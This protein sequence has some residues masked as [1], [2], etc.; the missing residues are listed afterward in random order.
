VSEDTLSVLDGSTFVV[1]DRHGDVRSGDGRVHGFFAEDTRFI[2]RWAL[3]V[4]DRPLQLLSLDQGTHFDAQFFLTPAVDP[5]EQAPWSIMRHRL[6]DHVWIEEIVFTNHLHV[7]S[8]IRLNLEVAADF[9]DLF[10]VKDV[11]FADR[12]VSFTQDS[13]G[14]TLAYRDGDFRRSV[15]VATSSTATI[16]REG[17]TYELELAPGQQ[18]ATTLTISPHAAQPGAQFTQRETRGTLASVRAARAAELE[19]W[20]QTAPSLE[21]EDPELLRTYRASLSD[22]AA[23][24]MHPD[25]HLGATLPAAGLPWFMAL[26]GR[27]SLI[28]SF[29]TLPYLP[30]LAATTLRVLSYRQAVDRDDFHERE[31]GKILHELRFGELTARG[32]RPHS[33]YFGT[34][35]ATPLFLVLLGEYHRWS[36]DDALVRELEGNA[37][38]ALRWIEESG[39]ADGDGFVEYERRNLQTG[40]VNQCWKDSWDSMQFADGTLARG[41]IATCEIQG[42]VYDA[43]RRSAVLARDVWGDEPFADR[44]EQ[45]ARDLRAR[46]QQK[47]WMPE[48]GC[49]ALAL[50]G[51]K[52]QVDSLTSNIGHLLWS[53]ILDD[54]E[55]AMTADLLV[56]EELYSGWG[57]RTLGN[58]EGG[59][60][61]L[62]YHTGTV[63]PHENSLIAAGM[64]RYGLKE[65]ARAITSATL[66]AAPHFEHR[67]PEVFAGFPAEVTSVPVAFPTA[68][69][70]QAWAAGAPLLLLTTL[71]GLTPQDAEAEADLPGAAGH[72]RLRR[73]VGEVSSPT[74]ITINHGVK[75]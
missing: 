65:H 32:E 45:R 18:W 19:T 3:S 20:L 72:I 28:T 68:S 35:D 38:A 9:A 75:T 8:S 70:P 7:H 23:L 55:A 51:E 73:D 16:S 25:L 61:P 62:G 66:A 33:P 27:D 67:L 6:V 10:E 40:L 21:S 43:Y 41:P 64:A 5:D 12:Q 47:F 31:P 74:T 56:G 4:G 50:D 36:G 14:F 37:R 39:D 13:A 30:G 24:R 26:F 15:N 46:F 42:Y 1:S 49:A 60:N 17:L 71:L 34:A 59:Y 2:S 52:R 44:L 22:L 53:G 57:V 29:Q 69:R 54:A 63:W 58:R 48:R 11:D